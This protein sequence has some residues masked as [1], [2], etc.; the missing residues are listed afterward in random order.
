MSWSQ[1]FHPHPKV[2]FSCAVPCGQESAGEYMDVVLVRREEPE[3]LL[4]RLQST[5]P[6]GFEALDV[7]E[8]A[9]GAP[10]LMS[11]V[12]GADYT[13]YL[14]QDDPDE[15]RARVS[16]LL[17]SEE[18]LVQRKA[19][20]KRKRGRPRPRPR[21]RDVDIRPMIQSMAL[22]D[23]EEEVAVSLSLRTVEGRGVRT[24]E[25]LALLTDS[26][27]SAR[28]LKHRTHLNR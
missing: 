15:L 13:V 21:F 16:K 23:Q 20:I 24:R 1:G 27:G 6:E 8:V 17:A 10:S 18:I 5:L 25:L 4:K 7:E 19:K 11:L 2:A 22:A 3:E 28:V 26:P 9:L 14:P 12:A